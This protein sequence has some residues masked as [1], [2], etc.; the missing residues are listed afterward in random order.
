MRCYKSIAK[1]RDKI[2]F[3]GKL[4]DYR[5]RFSLFLFKNI[6]DFVDFVD[7]DFNMLFFML[8]YIYN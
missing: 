3:S 4:K 6:V 1:N 2:K 8:L 7:F 5:N